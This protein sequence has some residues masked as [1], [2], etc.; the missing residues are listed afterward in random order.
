M[1]VQRVGS[2]ITPYFKDGPVRRWDDA[3][4]ADTK[5]FGAWH[6]AMLENGVH[7]PPAQYEAGFLSITH[8][9]A[10]L[11]ATE[12]AFRAALKAV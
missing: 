6:A 3:A 8:D 2:M 7:W 11:S 1:T 4:Q 5:A 10:A 12:D 9:D